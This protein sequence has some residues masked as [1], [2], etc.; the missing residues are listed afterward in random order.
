MCYRMKYFYCSWRIRCRRVAGRGADHRRCG[1]C[2]EGP[3]IPN[4]IK[5]HSGRDGVLQPREV[6]R[7]SVRPYAASATFSNSAALLQGTLNLVQRPVER[8]TAAVTTPSRYRQRRSSPYLHED[9]LSPSKT[10]FEAKFGYNRHESRLSPT[11]DP[12]RDGICSKNQDEFSSTGSLVPYGTKLVYVR[13]SSSEASFQRLRSRAR[14]RRYPTARALS[15]RR[16]IS[17]RRS[18]TY[19]SPNAKWPFTVNLSPLPQADV[20]GECRHSEIRTSTSGGS[21]P[22]TSSGG[23]FLEPERLRPHLRQAGRDRYRTTLSDSYG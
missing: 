15:S 1:R 17:M 6:P 21:S 7:P 13:S 19:K 16:V 18:V 23:R 11:T 4:E 2:P 14:S 10:K 5:I 12:R 3:C 8:R 9:P 20:C 22:R